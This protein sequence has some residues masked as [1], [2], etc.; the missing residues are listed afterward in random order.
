MLM[1]ILMTAM[2]TSLPMKTMPRN[3]ETALLRKVKS[4]ITA[5][6]TA[7]PT[8]L[9]AKRAANSARKNAKNRQVQSLTAVTVRNRATKS[10]TRLILNPAKARE[11]V[12]P[13]LTTARSQ[14]FL[15]ELFPKMHSG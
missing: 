15:A 13:A 8:A 14:H 10:A 5:A 12:L 1:P 4:A 7:K 3:A 11:S 2:K 9:T 6:T